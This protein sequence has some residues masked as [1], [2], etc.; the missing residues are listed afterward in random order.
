MPWL[1]ESVGPAGMQSLQLKHA[2][3]LSRLRHASEGAASLAYLTWVQ[4]TVSGLLF[5]SARS[6]RSSGVHTAGK[7][8]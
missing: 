5:I 7:N 3:Q 1:P 2:M 8:R 6:L 4:R